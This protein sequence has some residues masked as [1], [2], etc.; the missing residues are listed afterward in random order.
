MA[1]TRTTGP[2]AARLTTKQRLAI[3]HNTAIPAQTMLALPDDQINFE[4]LKKHAIN[5]VNMLAARLTPLELKSRGVVNAADLASIGFDALHLTNSLFCESCVSA[6]GAED[7]LAAFIRAPIDCVAVGGTCCMEQLH[8]NTEI[9]LAKC[10]GAGTE[11][12]AVLKQTPLIGVSASTLLDT[13]LRRP[14]LTDLGLSWCA[15][16]EGTGASPE[17][18]IKLG[19]SFT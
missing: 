12:A 2:T 10:A 6:Y 14:Q 3:V 15:I 17:Q 5:P 4:F 18:L 9:L 13:G 16:V 19:Y 11:A 8:L 7:V 1:T